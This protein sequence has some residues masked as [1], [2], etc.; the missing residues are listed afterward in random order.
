MRPDRR[1]QKARAFTLVEALIV[2]VIIS[3]LAALVYVAVGASVKAARK[4]ADQQYLRALGLSIE[5]FK[6]QF[7][8]LPPLVDDAN[9][10]GPIDTTNYRPRLAGEALGGAGATTR[11][12]RY[13]ADPAGRRYSEYSL[14]YY[15]L[16]ILN[17]DYDGVDGAG[18]TQPQADGTFSRRGRKFDPLFDSASTPERI[19]RAGAQNE[20]TVLLDRNGLPIRYYR[21]SP[22]AHG[23]GAGLPSVYPGVV[24]NDPA[25]DGEIRSYNVPVILGDPKENQALRSAGWALLAAGADRVLDDVSGS[26]ARNIDNVVIVEG[27][28]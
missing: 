20:R 27:G 2:F 9:A 17:K 4:S 26:D 6:Q 15:L 13:E 11:Y 28:S 8:F 14:S 19:A 21:W 10:G 16:G 23:K 5:Q 3:L 25:R 12:L 24:G 1:A 22:T 18:F 7:G